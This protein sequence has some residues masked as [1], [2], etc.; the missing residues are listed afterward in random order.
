LSL[1]LPPSS[2]LLPYT[3]LFRS[4]AGHGAAGHAR[5]DHRPVAAAVVRGDG[6]ADRLA[7]AARDRH[8]LDRPYHLLLVLRGDRGDGASARTGSVDRRSG[9]GPRCAALEGVLPEHHA[10]DRAFAGGRR[11]ALLRV[12]AG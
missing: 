6:A 3:T 11:H 10:D 5:G 1:R 8:H 2:L 12:V 9:D 4:R 7:A